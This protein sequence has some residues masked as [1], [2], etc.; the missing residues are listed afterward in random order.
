ME[1]VRRH[2]APIGIV[3]GLLIAAVVIEG[4]AIWNLWHRML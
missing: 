4:M 2:V 1:D 3:L